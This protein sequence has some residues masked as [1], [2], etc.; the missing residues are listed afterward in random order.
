MRS[1]ILAVAGL[2]ACALSATAGAA[3][4]RCMAP[5][6]LTYVA[7]PLPQVA[8]RLAAR[9]EISV[10][11]LGTSSSMTPQRTGMPKSYIA[12][13]PSALERRLPGLQLR[14][15]NRSARRLTAE[16]MAESITASI[17]ASRPDLVLWQTGNVEAAQ[18]IDVNHFGEA[19]ERGLEAL[20]AAGIGVVLIAPQYRA[21]LAALIDP[22]PYDKAMSQIA[23]I[24][25]I[26]LFP[27]YE[28]MRQ[29]NEDEV[30][31]LRSSDRAEQ[32]REA[33]A[34]N[35]CLAELLAD[36]IAEAAMLAAPRAR[37]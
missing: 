18:H 12:S 36:M 24:Q 17:A 15:D 7:A 28:I 34:E 20:K 5:D 29:W 8:R 10:V 1:S 4:K 16:Q 14:L 23:D 35:R 26:T 11:V 21:R 9:E 2:L 30:F 31:S 13:L 25:G 19:L 6:G 22:A 33:E 3:D 27:R 32:L 37:P